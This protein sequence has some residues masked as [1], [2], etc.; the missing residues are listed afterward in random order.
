MS[1]DH[2]AF[3]LFKNF[4]V[5][6]ILEKPL[7]P[8]DILKKIQL[9][10]RETNYLPIQHSIC[11]DYQLFYYFGQRM[12]NIK[13]SNKSKSLATKNPIDLNVISKA[14]FIR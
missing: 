11:I 14:S 1:G 10:K 7:S 9:A 5:V 13:E 6:N 12:G 8:T 4:R 3:V 2:G